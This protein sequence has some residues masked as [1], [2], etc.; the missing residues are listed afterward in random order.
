[1]KNFVSHGDKV[2]V[3]APANVA[4]GQAIL[5]EA[6]F[7]VAQGAA[8]AGQPVVL[9]TMGIVTLPK[10]STQAWTVGAKVYWDD[11]N[12]R[13]TTVASGNTLIGVAAAPTGSGAEFTTGDVRLGIVA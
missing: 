4:S 1:M 5:I 6:L 8:M 3:E 10:V 2:T 7:G 13:C 9:V 12:A 11:G